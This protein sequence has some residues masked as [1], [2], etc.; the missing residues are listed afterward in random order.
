MKNY[1]ILS[2]FIGILMLIALLSSAITQAAQKS[3]Q[4]DELLSLTAV[5]I[6][7]N[8]LIIQGNKNFTYTLYKASDPYR[9]TVEIPDMTPGIFTDKIVA[10]GSVVAEVVPQ[11]IDSPRLMTRLD[12]VLQS[13][14]S[15]TAAYKDNTL[16]LS[17]KKE[18]PVLPAE[19]K[20][21][22]SDMKP[23]V[24]L[25]AI[26]TPAEKET[27]PVTSRAT[28]INSITIKKSAD[29]VKVIISGNG[30]MIPNVF[31]VNERIV[32]DIP[33]A[34]LRTAL[35][36]QT[37]SP[38]KGIRAGKHK[39]KLR[40]VLDLKE[41]TNF[42]V[43]AIGNTIEI[44]LIAKEAAQ[45]QGAANADR[46]FAASTTAGAAP[47][48]SEPAV[49]KESASSPAEGGV[50]TG[51]K[52]SLD[53]QDADIIPI[54]RLLGDISGY[55][56]VVNPEIKGKIT[57]KLINVPWDQALDIV[58]RTFSLSKITDGTVIRI[59]P[60]SVVSK[61]LEDMAKAKKAAADAGEL[62]TK[63]FQ[64]NYAD[65]KNLMSAIDKAKLLSA[66]GSISLDER[67]SSLIANDV[68]KNL[69]KIGSLIKDLD[70][71]QMQARQVIIE[72]RIVEINNDYSK[73]L[74]ISWGAFFRNP[75]SLGDNNFFVNQ[76][77]TGTQ[78][79]TS[80]STSTTTTTPVDP[81]VNLPAKNIAG[82]IGLGYINRAA[83]FALNVQLSAMET[84]GNGK[85]ISSPR[86]MTM[87][88]ETAKIVQGRKLQ[89]PSTDNDGKPKLQEVPINLE[90][91]VTPRI[92]PSGAIQMKTKIKK[93]EFLNLITAGS[94]VG[95]D[96][97]QNEIN[98][99]VLINS[100]ET[101]VI[102]GIFKQSK[103]DN[104][105]GIPALSKL[106]LLGR[107][108]KR[109]SNKDTTTELMIF[110]TPRVVD[111]TSMK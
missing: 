4:A 6:E 86:I 1:K 33:D 18:E 17:V 48:V 79:T 78:T 94:N 108:F 71:E 50:Y 32:V 39:D 101:L 84:S 24:R 9:A 5:R 81:L 61:E 90:L 10:N 72:A 110:L 14:S 87:N 62:R 74:G 38:L 16:I 55:N 97:T 46:E 76:T 54:F 77:G 34:A 65:T 12:I 35:P 21:L 64:I 57:L 109:T 59:V 20:S 58:L 56:V 36:S 27:A 73:D 2:P 100:G 11:Q 42:D 31:P 104:E 30:T 44:S 15:F 88:N 99:T 28:E 25:A 43:T 13:P 53:F 75:P 3:S 7:N 22:E 70:Q 107:L 29:T 105:D 69:E 89:L 26:E 103:T 106:P 80:T 49:T 67:G 91:E 82:Q 37:M 41:K 63:I 111:F 68:E 66:R 23:L 83:T 95:V 92:T 51:K 47:F 52:I 60:N 93:D 40:I 98:T 19:A 85:I 96:T 45:P 8:S 102:G